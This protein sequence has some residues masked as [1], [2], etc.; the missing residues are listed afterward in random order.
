[1]IDH[2]LHNLYDFP[3]QRAIYVYVAT[4]FMN[5]KQNS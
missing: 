3:E 5:K 4:E 2:I 1:M